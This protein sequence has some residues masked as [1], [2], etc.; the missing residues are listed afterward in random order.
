MNLIKKYNIFIYRLYCW[1][2]FSVHLCKNKCSKKSNIC[3]FYCDKLYDC[4]VFYSPEG[5]FK[6][7]KCHYEI[8]EEDFKWLE[9]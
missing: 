3:C 8:Y 1:K 7:K 6:P 2:S 4:M 5:Y 9:F